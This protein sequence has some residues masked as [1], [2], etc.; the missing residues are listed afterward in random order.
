M[1]NYALIIKHYAL[2][3][4][5][6]HTSIAM[7][8]RLLALGIMLLP[9][10]CGVPEGQLRISGEYKGQQQADFL[11]VST[12]GGLDY[13]DTLHIVREE[14]DYRTSLSGDATFSIIYPGNTLQLTLWA[15]SGD[16]IRVSGSKD[17][18][19]HVSVEGNAENE[20]YTA[21]RQQCE[22]TDTATLRR[23][24]A[25]LIRQHPDS[26]VA[27][28]LLT[29]YFVLPNDLPAD[30][31]SRL[32][33]TLLHAQPNEPQVIELGGRIHQK[34]LLR[35]GKALPDFDLTTTDSTH[36]RLSDY[37]G[38]TLILYFWA[39]WQG[40]SQTLHRDVVEARNTA[41]QQGRN[42]KLLG[43]SLDV[44][45][46]TLAV[47]RSTD[48]LA[49]PTYCDYLGF[50]SPYAKQLGINNLPLLLVIDPKGKIEYVT[51]S[52]TDAK[53]FV[54]NKK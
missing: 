24:A 25:Q 16:H 20:L 12:D 17:D 2:N 5:A 40:Y 43:Y 52:S 49:V 50:D 7:G 3:A 10:A 33:R 42:I 11:I 18:L 27:T 54:T 13:I 6:L 34:Q 21:F 28:Y 26:R 35:R 41:Q 51:K 4:T 1:K 14:F 48:S 29:Q 39:G 53:K 19:W 30:S 36:H 22:A 37:R 45:S 38:N 9:A 44:D 46:L 15:H 8:A 47:N 23:T 32:Y 31:I